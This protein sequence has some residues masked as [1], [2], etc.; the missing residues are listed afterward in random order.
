MSDERW[1]DDIA[2]AFS[3]HR[4]WLRIFGLWPFG[5]FTIFMRMRHIFIMFINAIIIPFVIMDFIWTKT[6]TGVNLESI[7]YLVGSIM[8]SV[9]FICIA[10]SRKRLHANL[11]AA[12][13]DWLLAKNDKDTWKIMRKYA[14]RSRILTFSILYA[15]LG[16]FFVYIFGIVFINLQQIFFMDPLEAN[17]TTINWMFLIPS[18]PLS[19]LVT[20]TQYIIIL[21]LQTF[22]LGL[23][24]VVQPVVDSFFFNV[25]MY[26]TSQ[27]EIVKNKFKSFANEPDTEANHRK[28]FAQLINRHNELMENYQNLEDS[29]HF[30]ILFQLVVT[31]LM[32]AIIGLRI[33]ISLNENNYLEATKSLLVLNYLLLQSLVL[34]YGGDFLQGESEGIFHALYMTSWFT[35]PVALMKDM[36]FAM[37][38]AS[39]PFRLTGGKFFY[40]NRETMMYIL[41]T[42]ASYISVLRIALLKS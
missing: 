25:T 10:V 34:T 6:N 12:M 16:C 7:L 38:R 15:G 14:F 36:H 33:N 9:K 22:Q 20:G 40:V 31:T 4:L 8:G 30:F 23:M 2:Y 19:S 1:N 42:A 3:T 5:K 21:A 37:M 35:F 24:C 17:S 27:L 41:R 11:N 29:F 13:D 39:V 32:L 18:G 26:L 28:K